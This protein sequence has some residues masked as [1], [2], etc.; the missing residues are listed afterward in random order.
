MIPLTPGLDINIKYAQLQTLARQDNAQQG[1]ETWQR[2]C[3]HWATGQTQTRVITVCIQIN[4][5]DQEAIMY[6]HW[7]LIQINYLG[8]G[9]SE[10][11]KNISLTRAPAIIAYIFSTDKWFFD[12][13][14]AI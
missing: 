3:M 11:T 6:L 2:L 5:T 14:S 1:E 8:L 9:C 10:Q 7:K 13:A 4:V 12:I